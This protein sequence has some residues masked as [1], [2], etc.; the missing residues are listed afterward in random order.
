MERVGGSGVPFY[1]VTDPFPVVALVGIWRP[2]V[3][4]ARQ[5]IE[6]LSAEELRAAVAHEMAHRGAH[7]N[8]KRVAIAWSPDVLGWL[9]AGRWLERQWAAAAERAADARAAAGSDCGRVHLARALVK[10]A[11]LTSTSCMRLSLFSTL[12][13]CGELAGRISLLMVETQ[14]SDGGRRQLP[15]AHSVVVGF[16]VSA[17]LACGSMHA[18]TELCI[19]LLP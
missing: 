16:A 15:W 4:I 7:D 9:G 1:A 3:F 11:R 8:A 12:H 5:V 6:R 13:E 14:L 2:R 18:L 17:L 19:T 10:V